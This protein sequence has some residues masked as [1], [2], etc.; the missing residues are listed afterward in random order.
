MAVEG[1]EHVFCPAVLPMHGKA[2]DR[3]TV[4][5]TVRD[6][7]ELGGAIKVAVRVESEASGG[8]E[9]RARLETVKCG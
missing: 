4:A 5:R 1:I 9:G 6:A 2:E 3:A 7:A 8:I